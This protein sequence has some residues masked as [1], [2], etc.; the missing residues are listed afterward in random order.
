MAE[1]TGFEEFLAQ[2]A[3][4]QPEPQTRTQA[5][6]F[7]Q[8]LSEN[9]ASS[10]PY[11]N[12]EFDVEQM[13]REDPRN[14][15]RAR[16]ALYRQYGV[17]RVDELPLQQRNAFMRYLHDQNIVGQGVNDAIGSSSI[18]EGQIEREAN[19][20]IGRGMVENGSAGGQFAGGLT[21]F[22]RGQSL[23]W[24]DELTGLGNAVWKGVESAAHLQNPIEGARRGYIEGAERSRGAQEAFAEQRPMVSGALEIGGGLA[25]VGPRVA[26]PGRIGAT[27]TGRVLSSGAVGGIMGGTYGAGVADG[28]LGERAANVPMNAVYGAVGGAAGDRLFAAADAVVSRLGS[29]AR[30]VLNAQPIGQIDRGAGRTLVNIL[31]ESGLSSDDIMSGLT[32]VNNRIQQGQGGVLVPSRLRDELIMEFGE[33][34]QGGIDSFLQGAAQRR[35]QTSGNQIRNAVQD[36]G[37]RTTEFLQDAASNR[38]AA[39]DRVG[40]RNLNREEMARIGR[41]GYDPII[42][43]GARDEASAEA[44]RSVLRAPRMQNLAKELSDD[45]EREGLDLARMI[46]D[47]PVRAAHWMQSMAN[48]LAQT[49]GTQNAQGRFQADRTMTNRRI[50]ILKALEDAA[51]G[52]RDAR[53]QFGDEVGNIE[54][55]RFGNRFFTNAK[56]QLD[57]ADMAEAY[58]AMTPMQQQAARM[59]VR[60]RML[61]NMT[62][63]DEFGGQSR[64]TETKRGDVQR[65]LVEVFGEDGESLV[66]DI[67]QAYRKQARD[68]SITFRSDT[69]PNVGKADFADQVTSGRLSRGLTQGLSF[70]TSPSQMRNA[71]ERIGSSGSPTRMD[72]TT[73]LLLKDVRPPRNALQDMIPE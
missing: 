47:Q 34:A 12:I 6:G 19:R 8:F 59:S 16:E 71:L 39:G 7:Q 56:D 67:A 18:S 26:A 62:E 5:T 58:Q 61:R 68:R 2:S 73:A 32:R 11:A 23:G 38:L 69:G 25:T 72:R 15:Q 55:L 3:G 45:A 31:R 36:D 30:T 70:L 66:D 42:A 24:G 14:P 40:T 54:A 50:D 44:L 17:E 63:P 46:Q 37:Q 22:Q 35:P 41:E 29:N 52:Y 64:L 28:G 48:E 53:M 57:T 65:A 4:S 27:T 43:R 49:R 1:R 13:Q 33:Q 10:S 9:G 21:S 51:P 20:S 60:D